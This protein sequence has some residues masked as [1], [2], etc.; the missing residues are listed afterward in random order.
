MG[1]CSFSPPFLMLVEC[2]LIYKVCNFIFADD[3][4]LPDLSEL[5]KILSGI[6][7]I[8]RARKDDEETAFRDP[9][10]KRDL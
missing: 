3:P 8:N 9:F 7:W 1:F 2:A 4:W 6:P 5:N 10:H